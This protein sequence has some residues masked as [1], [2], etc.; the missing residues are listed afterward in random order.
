VSTRLPALTPE[1]LDEAQRELYDSLVANEI[2]LF[3]Q[4]GVEVVAPDGSLLGPFGPLLLSPAFGAAWIRVFRAD[5]ATTSLPPRVH[6]IVILTV[7]AAWSSEYELYAHSIVGE[8]TGLSDET[9]QALTSRRPPDLQDEGEAAAYEFTRRLTDDHRVDS[10]TYAR[11]A[12]AFGQKGVADLVL[13]VGLY[14]ATCS[15]INAFGVRVP[16]AVPST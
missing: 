3:E 8:L 5:K 13:L 1:D 12:E 9:I 16:E 4:A 11:A 2:P 15:I 14:L 10:E 7:G 6:E